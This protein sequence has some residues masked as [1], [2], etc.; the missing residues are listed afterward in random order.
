[1]PAAASGAISVGAVAAIRRDRGRAGRGRARDRPA[2]TPPSSGP[3]ARAT[4][5]SMPRWRSDAC[6]VSASSRWSSTIAMVGMFSTP[7]LWW[8]WRRSGAGPRPPAWSERLSFRRR[9]VRPGA[10]SRTW[11]VIAAA[12]VCRPRPLP[13]ADVEPRTPGS[14]R[15]SRSLAGIPAPSSSTMTTT[16]EPCR[17][18][19]TLTWAP[20]A[21]T[22]AFASRLASAVAV[23]VGRPTTR[24]AP[25]STSTTPPAS[26]CDSTTDSSTSVSAELLE[27]ARRWSVSSVS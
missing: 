19:C 16:V 23:A 21:W 11:P 13:A 25:S 8:R 12:A 10:A 2:R 6:N 7:A 1:M 26:R 17:S 4:V 20:G 15:R 24:T 27:S 18:A 14:S 22:R 9:G 5:A 3:R